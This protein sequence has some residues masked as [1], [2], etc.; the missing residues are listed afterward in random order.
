MRSEIWRRSV[1]AISD[2]WIVFTTG[3]LTLFEV[4]L[5]LVLALCSGFILSTFV[6]D[7]VPA[8]VSGRL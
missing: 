3:C 4:L 7:S 1:I 8:N 2:F 6:L 5:I